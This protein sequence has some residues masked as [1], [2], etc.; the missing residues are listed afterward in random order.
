M[1]ENL[2][3]EAVGEENRRRALEAVQRNRGAADGPDRAS[4]SGQ[5]GDW[6]FPEIR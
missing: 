4:D 3:E 5:A 6:R 2:M 1:Y